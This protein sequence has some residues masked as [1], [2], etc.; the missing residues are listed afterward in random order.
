MKE[1]SIK[2]ENDNPHL[3][4]DELVEIGTKYN[5]IFTTFQ[6]LDKKLANWT[7][8]SA[9]TK[10]KWDKILSQ[11][12]INALIKQ[13]EL[14]A[15]QALEMKNNTKW[16]KILTVIIIVVTVIGLIINLFI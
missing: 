7:P 16:F 12:Q 11:Q 3:S 13:N 8:L 14:L 1:E 10:D 2:L 15:L 9:N 6:K 5:Q 4:D